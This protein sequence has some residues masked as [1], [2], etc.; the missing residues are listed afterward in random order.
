[1][2][3]A[4][5]YQYKILPVSPYW[6][7]RNCSGCKGKSSYQSTGNF[8][9]N[10]NGR[11]VDVWL[12]YQCE[13]C[14]HTFNLTIYER[15]DP[16][17]IPK[18]EYEAFLDNDA[19]MALLLGTDRALLARNHVRIDE[20]SMEYRIVPKEGVGE[21]DILSEVSLS[22]LN[23]GDILEIEV[24]G[25]CRIRPQ[26][27]FAQLLQVS[28]SR[29]KALEQKEALL[30]E[31]DGRLIRATALETIILDNY[32]LPFADIQLCSMH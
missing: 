23:A 9:V 11:Q 16:K 20:Q 1:M 15:R 25:M 7:I 12:I 5:K 32:G 31:Q 10:A 29:I 30:M 26:K 8:R 18:Q 19:D 2:S 4:K 27:L 21:E 17:T 13:K 6:I 22:I 28:V 24:P 14:R 3:C